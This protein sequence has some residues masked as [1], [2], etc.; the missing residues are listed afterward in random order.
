MKR[1]NRIID[2]M[3]L[4]L[5]L[6]LAPF[7]AIQTARAATIG[8]LDYAEHSV[9]SDRLARI[10]TFMARDSVRAQL[11]GLGVD[12]KDVDSRLATL[13]DEELAQIDQRIGALPA[14]G[15]GF[16]AVVGIVF[17][18]LIILELCGVTHIFSK[19]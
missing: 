2:A 12:T 19:F 18:V 5:A 3:M 10:H 15:D 14:G 13:T 11:V 6:N 4:V 17:L 16:F 8:S 1:R 7:G 9:R